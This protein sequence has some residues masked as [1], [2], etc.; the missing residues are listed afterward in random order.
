MVNLRDRGKVKR[1][2][3]QASLMKVLAEYLG[4]CRGLISPALDL[5]NCMLVCRRA[6]NKIK[7]LVVAV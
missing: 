7:I 6:G 2:G 5:R 3:G 1:F 4:G